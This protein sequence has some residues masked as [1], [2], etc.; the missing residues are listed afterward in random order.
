MDSEVIT[1]IAQHPRRLILASFVPF[2]G[3]EPFEPAAAFF[4]VPAQDFCDTAFVQVEFGFIAADEPG[5]ESAQSGLMAND[6]DCPA[7]EP[8]QEFHD[9]AGS[10]FEADF[11]ECMCW[12]FWAFDL[13]QILLCRL[14]GTDVG[15]YNQCVKP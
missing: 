13:G 11:L 6:A 12:R 10:N 2:A 1:A 15:A 4:Q 14:L 7:A 9:F 3:D 5:C 8:F